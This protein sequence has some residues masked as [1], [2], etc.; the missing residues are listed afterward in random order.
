MV[1]DA[2]AMFSAL[3]H[4]VKKGVQ[5]QVYVDT[6]GDAALYQE[7]LAKRY[8]GIRQAKPRCSSLHTQII[9]HQRTLRPP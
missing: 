5:L 1:D 3:L 2:A 7:R 4:S 6:V 9:C 8:P